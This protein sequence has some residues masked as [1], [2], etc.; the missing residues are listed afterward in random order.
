MH[1]LESKFKKNILNTKDFNNSI[2][3]N[4]IKILFYTISLSISAKI[5]FYLPFSVVPFTFQML[6]I[7]FIIFNENKKIAFLTIFSY[8]LAGIFELPV[9]AN[10]NGIMTILGPTGGYIIG[11]LFSS[12]TAVEEKNILKVNNK[13]IQRYLFLTIKG[14]SAI[15]IIY[16]FGFLGLLRFMSPDMAF[17]NGVLPFIIF[18]FYKLFIAILIYSKINFIG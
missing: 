9:F 3:Y 8:I 4:F 6:V 17:L 13:K 1:I 5:K 16:L 14:I 10:S 12:L 15:T 7:F 18:D 2:I 11:F